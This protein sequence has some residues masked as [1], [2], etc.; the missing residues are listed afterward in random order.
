M[1]LVSACSDTGGPSPVPDR[2]H[3]VRAGQQTSTRRRSTAGPCLTS[4]RADLAGRAGRRTGSSSR[5]VKPTEPTGTVPDECRWRKPP[6]A[7]RASLVTDRFE[8]P[9]VEARWPGD[10]IR[11]TMQVLHIVVWIPRSGE[12]MSMAPTKRSWRITPIPIRNGPP[13]GRGIRSSLDPDLIFIQNSDGTNRFGLVQGCC[14]DWSPDG[15]HIA[16]AHNTRIHLVEPTG[17]NDRILASP[18][19]SAYRLRDPNGHRTVPESH[20]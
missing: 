19:I 9:G 18:A 20:S 10:H 12:S 4:S 17:T 11:R 6:S 2:G 13:T 3:R 7:R 14:V 8:R 1:L 16:Y 15:A 5:H